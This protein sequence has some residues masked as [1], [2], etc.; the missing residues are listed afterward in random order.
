MPAKSKAQQS[1]MAIAKYNPGALYPEN[2]SVLSMSKEEL[3]KYASTKRKGLPKRVKKGKNYL[4]SL[5]S[6]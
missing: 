2:R 3:H 1:L 6:D 4:R 5:M